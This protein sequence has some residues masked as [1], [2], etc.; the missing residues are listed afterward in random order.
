MVLAGAVVPARA[1][2]T[3][4][5][6]VAK[7]LRE[8]GKLRGCQATENA[9]ALEAKQADPGKCQ[10]RFH[11][12]LARLDAQ[13]TAAAIACRYGAN[14]DGTVTDY[15]SGLQW[16]QKT[17]DGTVHD[18]GN[19]YTWNTTP[20]ETNPDGTAFTTFLGA[21]NYETPMGGCFAGH[22]DWRVPSISELQTIKD[23][24]VPGC[25]I[26]GP[27]IDHVFGPTA[28]FYY[29]SATSTPANPLGDD[30]AYIETFGGGFDVNP[31]GRKSNSYLVRAVR[32]GW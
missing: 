11:S 26:D 2:L 12:S 30:Y 9:K 22:C 6:C 5:E 3:T 7:K 19:F 32:S 31:F 10:T 24:S 8:L 23:P 13:A 4:P 16:E 1:V 28:S 15:D 17:D 18:V 21:L 25:G 29:W 20:G 27:C 14:G